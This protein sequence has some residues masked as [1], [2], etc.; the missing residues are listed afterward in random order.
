MSLAFQP[1]SSPGA[2]RDLFVDLSGALETGERLSSVDIVSGHAS[3]LAVSNVEVN[4]EELVHEGVSTEIGQGVHFTIE[5]LQESRARIPISVEFSG[6]NGTVD[7]Y[8]V[9]QPIVPA[10][11]S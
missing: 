3:V 10:L 2:K 4:T 7:R 6:D 8:Q 11:N 1:I 9:D 5:T